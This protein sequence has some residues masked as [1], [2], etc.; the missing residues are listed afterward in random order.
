MKSDPGKSKK[1][2]RREKFRIW[3]CRFLKKTFVFVVLFTATLSIIAIDTQAGSTVGNE[4]FFSSSFIRKNSK[5][6]EVK[7]MGIEI[8]LSGGIASGAEEKGS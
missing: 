5:E 8:F 3:L 2:V 1:T 7:I 6:V 4:S